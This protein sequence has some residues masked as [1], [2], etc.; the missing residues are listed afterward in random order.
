[1]TR[2]PQYPRAEVAAWTGPG[3]NRQ[4]FVPGP[5][6]IWCHKLDRNDYAAVHD[7]TNYAIP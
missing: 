5:R 2:F 6:R 7:P 1:M 4:L 3:A